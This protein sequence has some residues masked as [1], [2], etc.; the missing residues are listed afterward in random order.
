M[1]NPEDMTVAE[2]KALRDTLNRLENAKLQEE[3]A[4]V[5]MA[6]TDLIE[7]AGYTVAQIFG[8]AKSHGKATRVRAK[9]KMKYRDYFGKNFVRADGN[10]TDEEK[11]EYR[12]NYID[13]K[14]SNPK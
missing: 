11:S 12:Q 7:K 4:N 14:Q 5:K 2:I 1:K 10:W 8:G 9:E 3:I 13:W 6:A